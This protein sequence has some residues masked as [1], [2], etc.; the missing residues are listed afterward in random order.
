MRRPTP[1]TATA[2]RRVGR[3]WVLTAAAALALPMALTYG[4]ARVD[5]A[6][7]A[8]SDVDLSSASKGLPAAIRPAES[9]EVGAQTTAEYLR[10][11]RSVV[12]ATCVSRRVDRGPGGNIFTY[13]RFRTEQIVKGEE[14][15]S[16][17]LRLLGGTLGDVTV[18]E[19]LDRPF[20]VSKQYVLLLG[21][22]NAD[23]HPTL[24]PAAVFAVGTEP[25][26][27]RTIVV[28]APDGLP[29]YDARSGAQVQANTGWA[30]LDDLL[31]SFRRAR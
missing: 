5:S 4:R 10:A 8:A 2:R 20:D 1:M 31:T 9:L 22:R 26:S 17:E 27:G 25:Q 28:P 13:Y 29:M 19:P 14:G 11:A 24:N 21:A 16:F 12:L 30:Y 6:T 18:S 3:T 15:A 23:G 7:A